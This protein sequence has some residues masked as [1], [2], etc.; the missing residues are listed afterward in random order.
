VSDCSEV[1][2]LGTNRMQLESSAGTA[3][4]RKVFEQAKNQLKLLGR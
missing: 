1:G 3:D 4:V 2:D